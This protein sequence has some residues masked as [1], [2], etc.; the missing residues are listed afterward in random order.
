VPILDL[1]LVADHAP[2]GLAQA[3]AD[4]AGGVLNATPG[5]VW[6]RI[7]ALPPAHYAENGVLAPEPPPVFVTVLHAHPPEGDQRAAEALALTEA[8]APVLQRLPERV[9]IEYAAAGADRIA[10]GGRLVT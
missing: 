7:Q 1:L 4:A 6:V 8:L 10:F 9:H 5:H 3:V 2:P